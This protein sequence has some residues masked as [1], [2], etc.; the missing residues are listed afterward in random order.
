MAVSG[1]ILEI[2]I[3]RFNG[4]SFTFFPKADTS[5][6]INYGG[7]RNADENS[8]DGSATFIQK[9]N[10]MPWSFEGT[11]T[12]YQ[13]EEGA[14]FLNNFAAD[15]VEG[16]FTITSVSEAIWV[17]SGVIVGDIS[18]DGNTG[19]LPVKFMGSRK[20]AKQA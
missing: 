12:W 3:E 6:T 1:D 8:I 16:K 9:K 14:E 18:P 17:G 13:T 20:L 11:I 10:R 5:S 15:T 2:K 19:E 4:D 7:F